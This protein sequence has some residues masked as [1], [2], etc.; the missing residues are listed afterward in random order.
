[1]AGGLLE[2]W[3]LEGSRR[4]RRGG[5]D[6]EGD[7]RRGGGWYGGRRLVRRDPEGADVEGDERRGGGG[8]EV[9]VTVEEDEGARP[10][11]GPAATLVARLLPS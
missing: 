1:V 9:V 5:A 2:G 6:A 7:R 8:T 11:R 10:R 4:G 3:P